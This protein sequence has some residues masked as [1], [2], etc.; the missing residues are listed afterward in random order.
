MSDN[1]NQQTIIPIEEG[2]RFE[3]QR[4]GKCCR[5]L[6][7]LLTT[8]ESTYFVNHHMD[9]KYTIS[10]KK[11]DKKVISIYPSKPPQKACVALSCADGSC[12]EH[13][14][15]CLIYGDRPT[16]CK[17]FPFVIRIYYH[18]PPTYEEILQSLRLEG[19]FNLNIRVKPYIHRI[20]DHRWLFLGCQ[21]HAGFCPGIGIG[22]P[23]DEYEIQAYIA[24]N[25]F[26][27]KTTE[28]D[29]ADTAICILDSLNINFKA[30]LEPFFKYESMIFEDEGV[31]I[32]LYEPIEG[33]LDENL[34]TMKIDDLHMG[35]IH[36]DEDI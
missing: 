12:C 21:V 4:C 18:R 29:M 26:M 33:R 14:N 19:K 20:D 28:D 10:I 7:R 24:K 6:N 25:L 3:C 9:I 30:D 8:D 15:D 11:V 1:E 27:F 22:D 13:T 35:T 34:G 36:L 2:F 16:V 23:W 17:L 31:E 32:G 5:E